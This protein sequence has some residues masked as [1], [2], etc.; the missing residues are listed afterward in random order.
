MESFGNCGRSGRNYTGAESVIAGR[1]AS[2]FEPKFYPENR[3]PTC[4][5]NGRFESEHCFKHHWKKGKSE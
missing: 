5:A 3:C 2:E 1:L 4:E